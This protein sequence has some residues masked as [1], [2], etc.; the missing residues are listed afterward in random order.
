M[1]PLTMTI[2][3]DQLLAEQNDL[4]DKAD[5]I[6]HQ[7]DMADARLQ[8]EHAPIDPEWKA[9][10]TYALKS[11]RRRINRIQQEIAGINR[12]KAKCQQT[13]FERKF[14]DIS[15]QELDS[16]TYDALLSKTSDAVG[17]NDSGAQTINQ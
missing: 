14:V 11:T 16:H 4:L 7:L 1:G 10:A 9:K 5:S 2:D 12:K 13:Q 17:E 8:K 15:R 6:E 3:R